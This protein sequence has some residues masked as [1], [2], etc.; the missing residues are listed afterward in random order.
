MSE[1]PWFRPVESAAAGP[2]CGSGPRPVAAEQ[3]ADGQTAAEQRVEQAK[4]VLMAVFGL[5]PSA[6]FEVLLWAARQATVPVAVLADRFLDGTRLVDFG[7][8]AGEELVQ[9]LVSLAGSPSTSP[10]PLAPDTRQRP[11]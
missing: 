10:A 4:G 7:P 6:A 9:L 3:T 2:A 1:N 5:A 11:G 8:G